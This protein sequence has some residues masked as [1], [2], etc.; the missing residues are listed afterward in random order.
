M[1]VPRAVAAG[2]HLVV[3]EQTDH[4]GVGKLVLARETGYP[5]DLSR[6]NTHLAEVEP[7]RTVAIRHPG[8]HGEP[9]TS[10]LFLP[11]AGGEAHRFPLIVI[12]YPGMVFGDTS[13]AWQEPNQPLNNISAQV[14]TGRGYAVLLPSLPR[15]REP[16]R[17]AAGLAD[18]VLEIVDRV[19]ARD[20]I[21]GTR[22]ALWGHSFGGYAAGVIATQTDRFRSIIASAGLFDLTSAYGTFLPPRRVHPE[23][24]L[25][26]NTM[27]GWAENGQPR[28]GAAPWI[29]SQ[30]YVA[31]S[32]I[33][34]AGRI[35]T[36]ML[37]LQGDQDI[38]SLAQAE[39]MFSALYRQNKDAI[40]VSYWGEGHVVASPANLRDLYARVFRWLDDQP[41]GPGR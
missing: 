31:N 22:L 13:P 24:G 39:E 7:A 21:D 25:S 23:D 41:P 12:P 9:L 38:A 10:W 5:T 27:T 36:P 20:D 16:G 14:L 18:Q 19:T 29:A 37:L 4:H 17:A 35:R 30:T 32:P 33:F 40:L 34:A 11:P 1:V 15:P 2:R 8:P 6:L 28:L 3:V 26:I